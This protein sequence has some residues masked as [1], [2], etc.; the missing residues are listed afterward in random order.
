MGTSQ[1]DMSEN[2]IEFSNA[3]CSLYNKVSDTN[4]LFKKILNYINE[5]YS[6]PNLYGKHVAHKFKISEKYLYTFF[7]NN[8]GISYG[9]YL[10]DIR[11]KKAAELLLNT[12][13]TITEISVKTGFNSQNTFYKAF[14]R[15]YKVTPRSFKT[16]NI[17]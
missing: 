15:V 17:T 16:K 10:E 11:L 14:K 8:M 2:L 9:T 3:I 13:M 7:K 5:N 12:Q 1:K 4:L 6:D